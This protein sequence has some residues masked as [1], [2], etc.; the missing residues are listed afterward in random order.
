MKAQRI[1]AIAFGA[2]N[3][4]G[5]QR[6]KI[7]IRKAVDQRFAFIDNHAF[8]AISPKVTPPAMAPVVVS[9][10]ANFDLPHKFAEKILCLWIVPANYQGFEYA[11]LM[12]C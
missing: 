8:E 9:G 12:P 3:Q 7:D 2:I 11:L 6:V 4:A 1:L 5:R 10:K